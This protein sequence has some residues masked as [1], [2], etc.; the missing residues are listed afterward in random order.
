VTEKQRVTIWKWAKDNVA[1]TDYKTVHDAIN[2][3]FFGGRAKPEWITDI[4]AGR[5]T[6]FKAHSV[7]K[8]KAQ[9]D[10]QQVVRRAQDLQRYAGTSVYGKVARTIWGSARILATIGHGIVFP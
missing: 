4:L 8:W 6:P 10:R 2:Q 1:F 3:K 7:A 9:Y 5:K